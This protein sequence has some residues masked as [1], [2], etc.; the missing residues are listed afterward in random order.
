MSL[1]APPVIDLREEMDESVA[2]AKAAGSGAKRKPNAI[3]IAVAKPGD[4]KTSFLI[5][6]LPRECN[7]TP[8]APGGLS[9]SASG[10][11][12]P[13]A[14][15][16]GSRQE[17]EM[18]ALQEDNPFDD[19]SEEKLQQLTG[20]HDLERVTS[21]QL[22]VDSTKQSVE[23]IGE[24]L[25]ALQQL[26]LQQSTLCSFRDLGTSL[27]S[28]RILWA[29]NCGIA[30]LDGIGALVS[31]QE[32]HLQH[33]R[34]SDISP[35]TMHDELRVVAFCPQ[36]T[37]LNLSANPVVTIGRYRQIIANFAP[38][39]ASLDDRAFTD[40]ERAKLSDQEIDDAILV[41]REELQAGVG[42]SERNLTLSDGVNHRR[43]E[44]GSPRRLSHSSS[45]ATFSGPS[46]DSSHND[47]SGSRLTHGTDIVF[48]GNV[49]SALRRHRY[50]S[51]AESSP[52]PRAAAGSGESGLDNTPN[53]R[54]S[55]SHGF[56]DRPKTPARRVSITDTLDRAREFDAHT[57]RS[58]GAILDELKTWQ[59]ESA[60][61]SHLG[62]TRDVD[63]DFILQ[64]ETSSRHKTSRRKG[65]VG[66]A[67]SSATAKIERRPRTSA[68]VL[69]TGGSVKEAFVEAAASFPPRPSSRGASSNQRNAN[70]FGSSAPVVD[71]LILDG[72]GDDDKRPCSPT[73]TTRGIFTTASHAGNALSRS[74][75]WNLEVLSPKVDITTAKRHLP[76]SLTSK[77]Q[78]ERSAVYR[79]RVSGN[80][81]GDADSSSDSDSDDE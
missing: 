59:L 54:P 8:V 26:R 45:S 53:S 20:S 4:A 33:N 19:I 29:M 42:D 56:P 41:H 78:R 28:L 35:L 64:Q 38:Q 12:S 74:H 81:E 63:A 67:S 50:E 13:L 9:A 76:S 72:S 69:R 17:T 22:S 5:R 15:K 48:A 40:G 44:G 1:V 32:L 61:S 34:V 60:G 70:A 14:R 21:L 71:I 3:A 18:E 11:L 39:L 31:L 24:L 37:A 7:P 80:D 62:V 75:E 52:Q 10:V 66:G 2:P 49:S 47:D 68:G 25:P 58:R 46:L 30:D 77:Q 79:S 73:K 43:Y 23:V 16:R 27:G 57:H 65:S 36:L 51:E 6:T 55:S